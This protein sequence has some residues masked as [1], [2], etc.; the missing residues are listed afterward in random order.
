MSMR[1]E[2]ADAR[3]AYAEQMLRAIADTYCGMLENGFMFRAKLDALTVRVKEYDG[4]MED[5]E[6]RVTRYGECSLILNMTGS[7]EIDAH[8]MA[9]EL[10]HCLISN[11]GFGAQ[12]RWCDDSVAAVTPLH[13]FYPDSAIR[14]FGM[15]EAMADVLAREAV[16]RTPGMGG[17]RRR[18]AGE[19]EK[20]LLAFAAC[21]GA[22]LHNMTRLDGEQMFG[23]KLH[24]PIEY[25]PFN[26]VEIIAAGRIYSNMFW[27]HMARMSLGEIARQYDELM[28]AGA[29]SGMLDLFD[30]ICRVERSTDL[31]S[32]NAEEK[33]FAMMLHNGSYDVLM[34]D[35]ARFRKLCEEQP[36]DFSERREVRESLRLVR[37]RI[38]QCCA[39]ALGLELTPSARDAVRALER[40]LKPASAE[41]GLCAAHELMAAVERHAQECDEL[42]RDA[43]DMR[44]MLGAALE[45]IGYYRLPAAER[46]KRNT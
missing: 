1:F 4:D 2:I 24:F 26:S 25:Y 35:I 18:P 3:L 5:G 16:Y 9:H 44:A 36:G 22:P 46:R 33:A 8:V 38:K 11:M 15:E 34:K 14:G 27:W 13:R 28:G 6:F 42:R 31:D 10:A 19:P 41:R 45:V 21:F 23:K 20:A 43:D 7:P 29:F 32:L 40:A 30:T 37:E 12:Q 17:R 39:H